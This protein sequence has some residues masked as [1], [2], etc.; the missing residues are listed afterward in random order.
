[1][2]DP[3]RFRATDA[4]AAG[5]GA[6][7]AFR[8]ALVVDQRLFDV[9]LD[10]GTVTLTGGDAYALYRVLA[11]GYQI[12][13]TPDAVVWHRHRREY[14][15]LRHTLYGYSV[16]GFAYLTKCLVEHGDLRALGS[17]I[18][19]VRTDHARLL[20]RVIRK[21]P[22]ALPA[23]LVLAYWKGIFVGPVAYVRSR[24]HG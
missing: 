14:G 15:S 18:T 19:W 16:G 17:M 4:G 23:D 7:V 3:Q 6:N 9:E 10:A 20:Y 13:Y 12:I 8:R 1:V 2:F 24:A 11:D 5:A 22:T 21:R